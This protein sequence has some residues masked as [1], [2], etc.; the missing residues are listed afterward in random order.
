MYHASGCK[1]RA[2]ATRRLGGGR[3][4]RRTVDQDHQWDVGDFRGSTSIGV[5]SLSSGHKPL[6]RQQGCSEDAGVVAKSGRLD[7]DALVRVGEDLLAR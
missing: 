4:N 6:P 1:A 2:S 3:R 5:P 7:L